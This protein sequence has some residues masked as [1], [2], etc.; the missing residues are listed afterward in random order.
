MLSYYTD[1]GP[2]VS[3]VSTPTI[4]F[5]FGDGAC[6]GH[7]GDSEAIVLDV[8]YRADWK[9]WLVEKAF[10]S[11]HD[12][13]NSFFR[14]SKSYPIALHYP[15]KKGGYPRAFVA[16]SKHANYSTDQSCDEG[17]VLQSDNCVSDTFERVVAGAQLNMGSRASHTSEQD[18]VHSSNPILPPEPVE[19]YWTE[20]RFSGWSDGSPAAGSYSAR[21]SNLSF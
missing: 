3:C 15:D 6:D 1:D 10:Y 11:K 5:F 13:Y 12:T 7:F 16:Y 9:H 21:L 18:C 17:G 14:G 20:K 2:V 19:C 8:Y 4:E